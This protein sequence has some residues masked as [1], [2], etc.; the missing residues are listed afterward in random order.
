[1]TFSHGSVPIKKTS[2][3]ADKYIEILRIVISTCQVDIFF[4]VIAGDVYQ[5]LAQKELGSEWH[6][7]LNST[8]LANIFSFVR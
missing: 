4:E 2:Y 6:C 8:L 5:R 7:P 3:K 1:M